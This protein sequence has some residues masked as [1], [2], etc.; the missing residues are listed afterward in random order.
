MDK[1]SISL[2]NIKKI[3]CDFDG[4]ITKNDSVNMFFELYADRSWVDYENLWTQGK[5]TS[6]ENAIKQVALLSPVTEKTL[7]D[8]INSIELN[9]YFLEFVDYLNKNQIELTIM[10]DGFD[11]FIEKTLKRFNIGNVKFFAN[12]LIY[13]DCR[14]SIEFPYHVKACKIGA[15]MCK[16]DKV[17]EKEYCYVGDGTSDLCVAKGATTLF[18]TKKL[19]KYCEEHKIK[20]YSFK[21]FEDIVKVLEK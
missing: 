15:G 6:Q 21:S 18:A 20:H 11:L 5:I 17:K 4:T 9:D 3:Y 16:C 14:F 7:N 1:N 19:D 12:H 8:F 13:K 10:S 2:S